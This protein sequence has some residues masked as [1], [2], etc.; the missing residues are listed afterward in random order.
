M[1]ICEF[2]FGG[3]VGSSHKSRNKPSFDGELAAD[4]MNLA[5]TGKIQ[6]MVEVGE[7]SLCCFSYRWSNPNIAGYF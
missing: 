4:S 7:I 1:T 2:C 6:D 3:E 5:I